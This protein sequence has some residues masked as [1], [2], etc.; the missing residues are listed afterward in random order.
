[1]FT[2]IIQDI[3]EVVFSQSIP[4]GMKLG[5]RPRGEHNQLD[6]GRLSERVSVGDSIAVNGACLTV[7]DVKDAVLRF[8]LSPETLSKCLAQ[9]WQRGT[10]VNLETALT[11]QAPLGGHLLCGHIDGLASLVKRR[12]GAGFATFVFVTDHTLGRYVASKG[13]VAIDGVSLTSNQVA[14]DRAQTTFE[15]ALVPHTLDNTTLGKLHVGDP[16]HIE[17]DQI[18]RYIDRVIR[19]DNR[20][21]SGH[22][23]T[24]EDTE[25]QGNTGGNSENER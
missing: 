23:G 15:V 20:F 6:P 24:R 7:T 9:S 1:M 13:S 5:I 14:D 16:V 4:G 10:E 12:A 11:L 21:A 3:G 17:V 19:F 18:A 8:D 22:A 2:G 25:T